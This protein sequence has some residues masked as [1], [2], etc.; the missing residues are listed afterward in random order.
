MTSMGDGTH[1]PSECNLVHLSYVRPLSQSLQKLRDRIRDEKI[2][3]D[4]DMFC[5]VWS[6]RA[7]PSAEYTWSTDEKKP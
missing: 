7:A 2:N 6:L 4:E 5:R 3:F 1:V